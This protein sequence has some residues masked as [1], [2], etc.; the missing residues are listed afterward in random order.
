[1]DLTP[2]GKSRPVQLVL[3]FDEASNLIHN[4]G[5]QAKDMRYSSLKRVL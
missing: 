3:A 1:M 2:A 5:T 4:D